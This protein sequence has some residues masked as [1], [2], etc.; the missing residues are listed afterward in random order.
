MNVRATV[1]MLDKSDIRVHYPP[2][3]ASASLVRLE[4]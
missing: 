3:G 4:K 1:E 2:L